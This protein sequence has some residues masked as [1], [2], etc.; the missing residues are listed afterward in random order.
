M[1]P[2]TSSAAWISS[3]WPGTIPIRITRHAN[4]IF[5]FSGW[6]ALGSRRQVSPPS[7]LRKTP[8]GEVPA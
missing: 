7:S 4:D 3:G 2:P 6:T 1:V 8:T 5:S